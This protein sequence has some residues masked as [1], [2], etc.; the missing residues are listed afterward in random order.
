MKK[1]NCYESPVI[2]EIETKLEGIVCQSGCGDDCPSYTGCSHGDGGD[3]PA[4]SV[5]GFPGL[6][7]TKN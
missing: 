7:G 4:C 1:T 6:P 3:A 2:K 5:G